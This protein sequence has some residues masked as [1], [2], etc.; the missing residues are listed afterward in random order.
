MD[1]LKK[2]MKLWLGINGLDTK[3]A[4]FISEKITKSYRDLYSIKT[5]LSE[6]EWGRVTEVNPELEPV[7]S[8]AEILFSLTTKE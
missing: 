7:I 6:E 3:K 8:Q 4:E 2:N 5:S 1:I